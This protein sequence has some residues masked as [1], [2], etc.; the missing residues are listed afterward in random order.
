MVEREN[1]SRLP[2]FWEARRLRDGNDAYVNTLTNFMSAQRPRPL[3]GGLLGE[4]GGGAAAA[5]SGAV[6]PL[7]KGAVDTAASPN[8][9]YS[10]LVL[11]FSPESCRLRLF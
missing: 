5:W 1:S 9:R 4:R 7:L 6:R 8:N 10:L 11:Y 2:P 3:R